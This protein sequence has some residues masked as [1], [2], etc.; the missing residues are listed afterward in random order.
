MKTL[1]E[2]FQK[3][4]LSKELAEDSVTALCGDQ[5]GGNQEEGQ[6]KDDV[7]SV[8]ESYKGG[9]KKRAGVPDIKTQKVSAKYGYDAIHDSAVDAVSPGT[10]KAGSYRIGEEEEGDDD[11]DEDVLDVL[12]GYR[13]ERKRKLSSAEKVQGE[14]YR[15]SSAGRMAA[16]MAGM[17]ARKPQKRLQRKKTAKKM[18]KLGPAKKGFRRVQ[19]WTDYDGKG[20]E[21]REDILENLSILAE[22]IDKDPT[23]RF[24]EFVEAFNH[25]AD[26]GE[27]L[28]IR[29]HE[30]GETELAEDA[31]ELATNAEAMLESMEELGGALT[32]EE[33]AD[34]EEA[35]AEALEETAAY[36]SEFE[37][38]MEDEDEDED[39]EMDEDEDDVSDILRAARSIAEAAKMAKGKKKLK[40]A[41]K[42]FQTG[43]KKKAKLGSVKRKTSKLSKFEKTLTKGRTDIKDPEKLGGYL[44]WHGSFNRGSGK[45][46]G[47]AHKSRGRK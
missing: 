47:Q 21:M 19:S 15:R 14:Q 18:G 23:D 39:D 32:L 17:E 7:L 16:R 11:M 40:G 31:I 45:S 24:N 42:K 33:D 4:G 5:S 44:R 9:A 3:M 35:L 37:S 26:I 22:A 13:Y 43:R 8:V 12:E 10:G 1:R 20:D 28:T 6:E 36:M 30:M 2:D 25:I 41:A 38:L 29:Y 34:L 27:I 46:K